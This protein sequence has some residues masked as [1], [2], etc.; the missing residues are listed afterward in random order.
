MKILYN[1]NYEKEM[2]ALTVFVPAHNGKRTDLLLVATLPI[3]LSI[4]IINSYAKSYLASEYAI[5]KRFY[6]NV[7]K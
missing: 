1:K 4:I 6:F 3:A 5:P 2:K 7:Y